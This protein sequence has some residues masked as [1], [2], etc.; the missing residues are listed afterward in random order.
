MR[1]HLRRTPVNV[2]R[3]DYLCECGEIVEF[4]GV[5]LSMNPPQYIHQCPTCKNEYPL[6]TRYPTLHYEEED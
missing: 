5:T 3:E 2:Y 6:H 1:K 4:T